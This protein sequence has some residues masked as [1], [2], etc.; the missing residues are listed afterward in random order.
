MH[1]GNLLLTTVNGKVIQVFWGNAIEIFKGVGLNPAKPGAIG[2]N[3]AAAVFLNK[4]NAP[5]ILT[6]EAQVMGELLGG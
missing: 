1:T 4:M 3:L 2:I 5:A 6:H